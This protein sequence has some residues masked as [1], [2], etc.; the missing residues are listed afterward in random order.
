M[1]VAGMWMYMA[2]MY[3]VR[4]IGR[5][6]SV[7]YR[8]RLPPKIA[9]PIRVAVTLFIPKKCNKKYYILSVC[10]SHCEVRKYN[11]STPIACISKWGSFKGKSP[12]ELVPKEPR[13]CYSKPLSY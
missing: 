10:C 1:Y 2:G 11:T 8:I 6:S 3:M 7:A 12:L 5:R 4:C 13:S 9:N